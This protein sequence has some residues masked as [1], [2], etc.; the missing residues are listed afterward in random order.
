MSALL[1]PAEQQ[2]VT[3]FGLF[4][5]EIIAWLDEN[6]DAQ[7]CLPSG[8]HDGRLKP[9]SGWAEPG[10]HHLI[11]AKP[12]ALDEPIPYRGALGLRRL[13]EAT[14]ARIQEAIA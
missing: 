9:C 8:N 12:R 6:T 4:D 1:A 5:E 11:L 10:A 14:I 3:R 7:G 13:D 2:E